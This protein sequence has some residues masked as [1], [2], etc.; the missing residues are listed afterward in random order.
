M[1]SN[2]RGFF[3][4]LLICAFAVAVGCA[5]QNIDADDD[6]SA[7]DDSADDDAADD[8]IADDDAQDDDADDD[9]TGGPPVRIDG[10]TLATAG[11]AIAR[12]A[13]GV[14]YLATD[15][16]GVL[17][18]YRY[19]QGQVAVDPVAQGGSWP[20]LAVDASGVLH[21]LYRDLAIAGL[22]YGRRDENGWT[23]T[24]ISKNARAGHL[25][26]APDGVAHVLFASA[27]AKQLIYATNAS[28]SFAQT[29]LRPLET[30][31]RVVAA[32]FALD[33][34]GRPHV[35]YVYG[36]L[37]PIPPT[38]IN[39]QTNVYYAATADGKA[40]QTEVVGNHPASAEIA[41]TMDQNGAA[42]LVYNW[43]WGNWPYYEYRGEHVYATNRSG[44]WVQQ[45]IAAATNESRY[46]LFV[47]PDGSARLI[48]NEPIDD[49][50]AIY[51][52]KSGS[53][54][55]AALPFPVHAFLDGIMA[56]GVMHLA[57]GDDLDGTLHYANNASGTFVDVPI[58][59]SKGAG[60]AYLM[61][62]GHG[63]MHL[64]YG[65][66]PFVGS[67]IPSGLQHAHYAGGDWP[68]ETVLADHVIGNFAAGAFGDDLFVCF[69]EEF[70]LYLGDN[71]DG[72]WSAQPLDLTGDLPAMALD[73]DGAAHVIWFNFPYP[74]NAYYQLN[75]ADNRSGGWI[76]QI[77]DDRAE[78]YY[79]IAADSHGAAHVAYLGPDNYTLLYA[80]N[81]S[82]AWQ[83][84][85]VYDGTGVA[86]ID[87]PTIAVGPDDHVHIVFGR[88]GGTYPDYTYEQIHAER[89]DNAWQVEQI[90]EKSEGWARVT[91]GEDGT[92]HV[93]Y[94]HTEGNRKS[95]IH[96]QKPLGGNWTKN[97]WVIDTSAATSPFSDLFYVDG[98]LV[99][100]DQTLHIAYELH[101]ALW[102]WA[103]YP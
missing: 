13:N 54:T 97:T 2:R 29:V 53:W 92:F 88:S 3:L 98:L 67:D 14:T 1:E 24:L 51:G 90:D 79:D 77:L 76:S 52:N 25:A 56:D 100:A 91:F 95:L 45:N 50:W 12:A 101:N 103:V 35:A 28:G 5:G 37:V 75:Y 63:E 49:H 19:D 4:F 72:A 27:D 17:N 39:F 55:G 82:G 58:E 78:Y 93:L 66:M 81:A 21:I 36:V 34:A 46:R 70:Q 44:A 73:A 9:T 94:S 23:I 87:L 6:Q 8:D 64:I 11:V 30:G 31:K 65:L 15:H 22:F 62:D 18:V 84:E 85:L 83:S 38:G 26:V 86:G 61:R 71:I 96:A 43:F 32:D 57:V 59:E 80:T 33:S 69:A 47:E 89:I 68:R 10:G 7:D 20:D 40:W 41:I 60:L 16:A 42:H 74:P 48:V 102:Y 99:D